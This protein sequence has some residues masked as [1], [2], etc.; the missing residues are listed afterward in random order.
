MVRVTPWRDGYLP[1][2]KLARL[3]EHIAVAAKA[4]VKLMPVRR[5]SAS[6]GISSSSQAGSCGQC[7]G[8]R[9]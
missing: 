3:G 4:R 7:C 8:D 5:N 6:F 1:V 9:C 2:R